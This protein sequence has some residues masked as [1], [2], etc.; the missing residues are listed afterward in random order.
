VLGDVP[1]DSEA[2]VVTSSI[3]RMCCHSFQICSGGRVCVRVFVGMEKLVYFSV[4]PAAV[5]KQTPVGYLRS[6]TNGFN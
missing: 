4:V 6:V 1:V 5:T 3:L 2:P